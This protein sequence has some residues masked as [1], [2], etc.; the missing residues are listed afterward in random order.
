MLLVFLG[1][2]RSSAASSSGGLDHVFTCQRN[3][4]HHPSRNLTG[5]KAPVVLVQAYCIMEHGHSSPL[6]VPKATHP[7]HPPHTYTFFHSFY[8]IKCYNLK[9]TLYYIII[10]SKMFLMIEAIWLYSLY[11]FQSYLHC[12]SINRLC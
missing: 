9:F 6:Q 7:P 1:A 8:C 12:Q 11:F 4:P 3:E 5:S 2:S 10:C